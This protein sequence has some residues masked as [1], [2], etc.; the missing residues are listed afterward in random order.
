[1]IDKSPCTRCGEEKRGET[2]WAKDDDLC[3]KCSAALMKDDL[4]TAKGELVYAEQKIA[5]LTEELKSL[6]DNLKFKDGVIRGLEISITRSHGGKE[7]DC[8]CR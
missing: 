5:Y 3:W 7:H 2:F 4:V 6:N 8:Y 1:V